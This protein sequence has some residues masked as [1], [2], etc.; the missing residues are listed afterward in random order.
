MT[1]LQVRLFIQGETLPIA[2]RSDPE[3]GEAR[4]PIAGE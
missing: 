1:G 3:V 4:R 2:A